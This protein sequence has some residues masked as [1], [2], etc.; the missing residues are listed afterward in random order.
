MQDVNVISMDW[1]H[2]ARKC[3]LESVFRDVTKVSGEM[4]TEMLQVLIS[5]GSEAEQFH[6]VGFGVGSH[7]AAVAGKMMHSRIGRITG[8]KAHLPFV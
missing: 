4:L 5:H 1:S 3:N 8:K 6:I 7:I 2:Y